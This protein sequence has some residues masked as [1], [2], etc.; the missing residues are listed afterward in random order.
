MTLAEITEQRPIEFEER[1]GGVV[2]G[3]SG[4]VRTPALYGAGSMLTVRPSRLS[5]SS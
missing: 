3:P 4:R 5:R 2:V 1:A